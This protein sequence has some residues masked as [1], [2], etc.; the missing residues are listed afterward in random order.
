MIPDH[1][2]RPGVAHQRDA[3]L[4]VLLGLGGRRL[5]GQRLRGDRAEGRAH[6][7]EEGGRVHV[8]HGGEH[9]V[10]RGV[11]GAEETLGVRR[12][13]ELHVPVPAD[14][15]AAIGVR[16]ERGGEE[17]FHE[18]ARRVVLV[19][20]AALLANHLALGVELAHHRRA[21]TLGLDA[22]PQRQP[23][24]G[25]AD[26]VGGDVDAGAGVEIL[27]TVGGVDRVDLVLDDER[28]RLLLRRGQAGFEG[29]EFRG[30]AAGALAALGVQVVDD[31]LD[32]LEQRALGR[33]VA[34]PERAR[35][36]EHHVL[37]QVREAAGPFGLLGRA[38]AKLHG[39]R[40][41]GGLVPR[42]H[43][44]AHPVGERL[45]DDPRLQVGHLPGDG[46]RR[47]GRT[48]SRRTRRR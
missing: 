16:D 12:A 33:P 6:Q 47:S 3:A 30:V 32:P 42:Q 14:D 1:Q 46:D 38:D 9:G 45:L 27:R 7:S 44:D 41:R 39:E 36:L 19:A 29:G 26:L 11:P 20:L 18:L 35:A 5:R 13:Q 48:R 22:R 40:D 34:R 31:R 17:Q 10:V 43:D 23:V 28:P 21:Q 37:E 2:L 24:G 8:P 25:Q 15:R 4:A